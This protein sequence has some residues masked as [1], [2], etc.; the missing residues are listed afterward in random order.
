MT[1]RLPSL[2]ALQA[3]E[4]AARCRSVTRAAAELDVTHSAVSHQL[5]LLEQDLDIKLI[6]RGAGGLRLTSEGA[7]LVPG[8]SRAFGTMA[9]A[10]HNARRTSTEGRIAMSCVPAVLSF[11]LMPK[12]KAA[13]ELF[14]NVRLHISPSND[15]ADVRSGQADIGIYYGDGRLPDLRVTLLSKIDLFPV[16]SPSLMNEIS[17]RTP[18][19]LRRHTLLHGDEG[20]EWNAWALNSKAPDP[21]NCRQYFFE[22]ARLAIE[23][24]LFGNGVA[25]GDTVTTRHLLRSG[26]LVSPF[27]LAVPA[28]N[29]FYLVCRQDV[30][31]ASLVAAFH[32]WISSAA[33]ETVSTEPPLWPGLPGMR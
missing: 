28:E 23:A 32:N 5:R 18:S 13:A 6:A 21:A 1:G 2:R 9:E 29:A 27:N 4:A 22:D 8:L 20:A 26:R 11:W 24:A 31:S 17:L 16:C 12:L 25:L 19:D 30:R 7:A 3:F 10:V 14:P 15:A 33:R